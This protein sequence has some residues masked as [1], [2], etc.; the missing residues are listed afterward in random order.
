[1][2]SGGGSRMP[3]ISPCPSVR[4]SMKAWRSRL[5][6][7]ARRIARG[8]HRQKRRLPALQTQRHF[9]I[10]SGGDLGEVEIPG[11]AEIEAELF[12]AAAGEQFEGAFHVRRGERLAVMPFD[13]LAQREGQR[14]A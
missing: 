6:A 9:M 12:R 10:A 1:M 11:G 3:P 7:I 8:E 5:S 2:P 13:P 14:G 4:M